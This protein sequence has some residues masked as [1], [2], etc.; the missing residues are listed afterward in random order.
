MRKLTRSA[1]GAAIAAGTVFAASS[2][3]A[4]YVINFNE[5]GS[6]VVMNASGSVNL[7]GLTRFGAGGGPTAT[8]VGPN[9][10]A[11]FVERPGEPTYLF[12]AVLPAPYLSA[13]VP[14]RVP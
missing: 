9:S 2:A 7:A 10:G 14:T 6:T 1:V 12:T 11:V 3:N 4:A 8:L 13:P 5:V